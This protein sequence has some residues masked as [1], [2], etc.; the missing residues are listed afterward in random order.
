MQ[1]RT[2][3]SL[4]GKRCVSK[5][6]PAQESSPEVQDVPLVSVVI[7]VFNG[8]RFMAEAIDSALGQSYPNVEIIAV[9]DGSTDGSVEILEKYNGRI[10]TLEQTNLGQASARNAGIITARGSWIAFLD[11]DDL[12]DTDKL[13]YQMKAVDVNCSVIY[14]SARIIDESGCTISSVRSPAKNTN[15]ALHDLILHNRLITSTALVRR[16][17]I[18]SVGMLDETNRFGADDYDLWL[19]LAATGHKFYYIPL[20]LAS[21]RL[22]GENMSHNSPI[23]CKGKQQ[24]LARISMKY[25]EA[26]GKQEK[27]AL[28]WRLA[29][30]DLQ[31]GIWHLRHGNYSEAAG[32]F[33][34]V[35]GIQPWR[36]EACMMFMLCNMPFRTQFLPALRRTNRAVKRLLHQHQET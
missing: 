11:Q 15:A 33:R 20:E 22:H 28:R 23:L 19:A 30:I 35:V 14:S 25:P 32:L 12:W 26:F 31:L 17:A 24:A 27:K 18:Y 7:P 6:M 8:E 36:L 5:I 9:N 13:L 3:P 21:Y 2:F 16:D 10:R 34:H 1:Y 4:S 29:D